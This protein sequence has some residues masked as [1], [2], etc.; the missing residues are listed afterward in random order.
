MGRPTPGRSTYTE[1][2]VYPSTQI[3]THGPDFGALN[4]ADIVISHLL[5]MKW[6]S[7]EDGGSWEILSGCKRVSTFLGIR[8]QS[9][10]PT[11]FFGPARP[12][13][14]P[15][16]TGLCRTLLTGSSIVPKPMPSF[17]LEAAV[18]SSNHQ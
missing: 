3:D 11:M 16:R 2:T 8:L 1:Y 9:V 12:S 6:R 7:G 15:G 5:L 13:T 10:Q 18:R 17:T 14:A 4:C